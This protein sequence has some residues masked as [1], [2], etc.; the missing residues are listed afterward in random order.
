MASDPILGRGFI[1][2]RDGPPVAGRHAPGTVRHVVLELRRLG[3]VVLDD[4]QRVLVKVKRQAVDRRQRLLGGR[5]DGAALLKGSHKSPLPLVQPPDHR[6][7]CFGDR[8]PL[9]QRQRD[10][11][12]LFDL[13]D[14]RRPALLK[15]D[16]RNGPASEDQKE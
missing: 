12:G 7:R 3:R 16:R 2:V 4:L 8:L 15:R 9:G 1:I 10:A 11:F 14:E 5:G 6:L 13:L